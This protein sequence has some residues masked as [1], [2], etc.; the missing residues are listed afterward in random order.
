MAGNPWNNAPTDPLSQDAYL[1]ISN[2]NNPTLNEIIGLLNQRNYMPRFVQNDGNSYAPATNTV[3]VSPSTFTLNSMTH[4]Y[5][6]ALLNAMTIDRIREEQTNRA[7]RS[8][9]T[10]QFIDGLNKTYVVPNK[11]KPQ[12]QLTDWEQY[13]YGPEEAPAWAVG[14][15]TNDDKAQVPSKPPMHL[16][17]TLATEQAI[18]RELYQRYL[19]QNKR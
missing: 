11:L 4:E 7:N 3:S 13:R 12:R 19:N 6:H 14:N 18:M 8:F 1:V 16:D 9:L 15:V 5:T 10:N 17:P 2:T